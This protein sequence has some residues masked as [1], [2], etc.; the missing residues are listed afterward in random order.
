MTTHADIQVFNQDGTPR[1][2]P[3]AELDLLDQ[4]KQTR[5][6]ILQR[7]ATENLAAIAKLADCTRAVHAAVKARDAI[8]IERDQKLPRL[9]HIDLLRAAGMNH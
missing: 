4:E 8:M 7:T 3:K 2:I 5:L 1:Q 6:A 9:S